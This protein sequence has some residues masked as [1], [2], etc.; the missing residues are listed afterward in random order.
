MVAGRKATDE[1]ERELR[2]DPEGFLAAKGPDPFS[3]YNEKA[4][5]LGLAD[6]AGKSE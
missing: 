5:N 2:K 3:D 6:C 4:T 1:V